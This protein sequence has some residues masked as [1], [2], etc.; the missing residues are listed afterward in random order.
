MIF[1]VQEK[2]ENLTVLKSSNFQI[3]SIAIE[4]LNLALF[5]SSNLHD[6]CAKG[7]V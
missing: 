3:V 5:K 7:T 2:G 4:E 6:F 1:F